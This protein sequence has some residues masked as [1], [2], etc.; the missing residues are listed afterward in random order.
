[1]ASRTDSGEGPH[2]AWG[3]GP[4]ERSSVRSIE[5]LDELL[6]RLQEEAAATQPFIV[7]LIV[8]GAGSL[9]MGLGLDDTVLS[10]TPASLD[11][12]YLR[13]AGPSEH[14]ND[15]VFYYYGDWT[16]FPR[17]SAIALNSGRAAMRF[18]FEGGVLSNEVKWVEV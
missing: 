15:L 1:M 18:F 14:G 8:P 2:L 16:E 17:E 9:G 12:P 6:D 11:P 13:S 5:E 10:Y 7:E 4:K 3:S